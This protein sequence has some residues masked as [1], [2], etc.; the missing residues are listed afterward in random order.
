MRTN[1]TRGEG[2]DV[3]RG[4]LGLLATM[5]ALL[6]ALSPA[7][8][9]A[10]D[11]PAAAPAAA[12][13]VAPAGLD[14]AATQKL[15]AEIDERQRNSGDYKSRV[16]IRSKERSKDEA[17][18]YEAVVYRRD[19]DD[20]FMI[21]FLEPKSER[22]KGYL[23]IDRNLWIYD[24]SVGRWERRTE[25]ERIA[26]TDS[27]RGD[28]DESNLATEYDNRYVAREKLGKFD[29]HVIELTV[30]KGIDV[31]WP[32][33]K[34]WVDADTGNVLK[35]QEF[36]ASGKLMRTSYTPKWAKV[37]SPSKGKDVWVPK[38]MRIF[39]E[40]EK[41]NSTIVLIK[42]TDLSALP[43]NIFTKAWLEAKSR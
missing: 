11:A 24:P 1:A 23:R 6:P 30:K 9:S 37:S 15:V 19:K 38:E 32:K 17:V 3:G 42:A 27:R 5:M 13:N 4:A 20:R 7:P 16:Y 8:A 40:V 10:T 35:R 12:D 28:F 14:A 39:D 21:L 25:R 43:A 26:G 41:G 34:L 22:G 36:A 29:V 33:L 18:V 2:I 31:A